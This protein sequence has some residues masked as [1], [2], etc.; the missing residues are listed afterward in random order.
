M[1]SVH[2]TAYPRLKDEFTEQE[3]FAI[4]TPTPEE[5]RFVAARYRQV[6]LQ[7]FLLIQLKLLQRLG[8]FIMLGSVPREVIQHICSRAQVRVPT[9]SALTRYD[10]SGTKQRHR[11]H[12]RQFVGFRELLPLDE[13]WLK[14]QA[15]QAARTKQERLLF[16][17]AN[18][19]I[20][21][22]RLNA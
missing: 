22:A 6:T 18:R 20:Y 17:D 19:Q 4:Y 7:T 2:E 13:V 12:L 11:T 1:S 9:K 14:E 15:F 3:L 10:K 5:L 8:Y 16:G 21:N